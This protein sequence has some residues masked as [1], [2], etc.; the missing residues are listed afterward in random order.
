MN[1]ISRKKNVESGRQFCWKYQSFIF[2]YFWKPLS[3]QRVTSQLNN[4]PVWVDEIRPWSTLHCLHKQR[5][6]Q[7]SDKFYQSFGCWKQCHFLTTNQH[8]PLD[9]ISSKTK[10]P[11]R[12][13]RECKLSNFTMVE[14]CLTCRVEVSQLQKNGLKTTIHSPVAWPIE[15]HVKQT[16]VSIFF[17]LSDELYSCVWSCLLDKFKCFSVLNISFISKALQ[18]LRLHLPQSAAS[19]VKSVWLTRTSPTTLKI[20]FAWP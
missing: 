9:S 17:F 13:K 16:L 18:G 1:N 11:N 8:Q 5:E 12:P 3:K 10:Q 6:N 19:K 14:V 2:F 7:R 20:I 4:V 15:L